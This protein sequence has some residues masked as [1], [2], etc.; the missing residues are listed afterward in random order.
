MKWGDVMVQ[1]TSCNTL[2]RAE[3][4]L[5]S[6]E[7]N[8][9]SAAKPTVEHWWAQDFSFMQ[10]KYVI[11][12]CCAGHSPESSASLYSIG[13]T[14]RDGRITNEDNAF[15]SEATV[16]RSSQVAEFNCFRWCLLCKR[17]FF[18]LI[19]I[20]FLFSLFVFWKVPVK[21]VQL[22]WR[23]RLEIVC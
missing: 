10:Q 4:E 13:T 22:F 1:Y 15:P 6:F 9:A 3:A 16:F 19:L 2:S 17:L 8:L 20:L 11:L 5:L 21:A 12:P 14:G 18:S 23:T 7:S